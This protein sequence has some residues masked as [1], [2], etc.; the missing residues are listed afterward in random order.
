VI[1]PLVVFKK[2]GFDC[3]VASIK[4]GEIPMDEASLNPPF[5]TKT[6]EDYLL[7]G[8]QT[9]RM[10]ALGN[11]LCAVSLGA[12]CIRL[13]APCRAFHQKYVDSCRRVL[14]CKVVFCKATML[15]QV[16]CQT[17]KFHQRE[18]WG[19]YKHASLLQVVFPA[20]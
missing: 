8:E 4:G 18:L 3:T 5:L 2:A 6:V 20:V 11:G 16:W 19:S 13:T 14:A 7:D 9:S 12:V 15:V 10:S 1:A 17:V